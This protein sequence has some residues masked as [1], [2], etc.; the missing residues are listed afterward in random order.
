MTDSLPAAF[1]ATLTATNPPAAWP[2]P[3]AALWWLAQDASGSDEAAWERAHALVQEASGR[4]AA[5]VHAHL[6]RIEGDADNARYWYDRAG[7][8]GP[9]GTLSEERAAIIAALSDPG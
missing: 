2:A 6:H 8:A 4:D 9:H 3:L 1:A 5:W 7:R